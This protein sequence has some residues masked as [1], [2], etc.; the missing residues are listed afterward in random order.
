MRTAAE[1]PLPPYRLARRVGGAVTPAEY[2]EVGGAVR[3]EIDRLLPDEWTFEGKRVLDFG[4]GAGR[5]LRHFLEEAERAEIWGCD[6]DAAS[7][8]WLQENL[9]PPLRVLRCEERPPLPHPDGHFDLIYAASVFTHLTDG[10]S[11]WLAEMHRLLAA[12]GL[13]VASF[14][15]H[16]HVANLSIGSRHE[17]GEGGA[18]VVEDRIGMNVI[19]HWERDWESGGPTVLHSDW[20]LRAH[21]G[22]AFEV[23]TIDHDP[24]HGPV[25]R[26]RWGLFR[27][28]AVEVS[29]AELERLEPDEPRELLAMRGSLGQAQRELGELRGSRSW[30]LTGPLRSA[31]GLAR[32]LLGRPSGVPG[33]SRPR[34]PSGAARLPLA[35]A[36]GRVSWRFRRRRLR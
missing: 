13:L 35:P 34:R 16:E 12:D 36:R 19:H 26:H 22:R 28:R 18:G 21:W 24:P 27:R 5:V 6:I 3:D 31:G 8:E 20:W 7:I 11:A 14:L 33:S 32:S 9:S 25:S 29:A 1:M 15:G 23:A 2:L 17:E 30:R 4:C 10:W